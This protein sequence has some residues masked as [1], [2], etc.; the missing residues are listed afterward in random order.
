MS[1][2]SRPYPV[3]S[4]VDFHHARGPEVEHW[5]GVEN[6]GDISEWPL[7]PF[8]ALADGAHSSEEDFSYFTLR[9]NGGNGTPST[10]FGIACTRQLD[11]RQLIDRPVDVTRSTVQKAVVVIADSPTYFFGHLKE[12][13]SAVTQAWFAQRDFEDLDIIKRFRESLQTSLDTTNEQ[14]QYVG[15][16][17][18]EIVYDFKYQAL[19][20]F[21]CML[22]QP[23][24]LFFSTRCER[25]C[26]IQFSLISLVPGLLRC[27]QDSS[28]PDLSSYEASLSK[29]TSVRTSD[30]KSL[31]TFMGLPLQI[32]GKGSLFGPYTPLQQLDVLADVGTKSYMVGSTNSLLLQ[33]KDRYSD[34]LINLDEKT[35]NVTSSSLRTALNLSAADRRWIDYLVQTVAESWDEADPSRPKTMGFMGSEEYI[36]LQFEEYILSMVSSVKYHLFLEKHSGSDQ[37]VFLSDIEG[38]PSQ[39]FNTEFV[40]YWKKTENFRIFQKFTDSEIFDLVTPRHVM[41]GGL[42]MEDVQRRIALQVQELHLD[43]K[44][45]A[46]KEA[47]AKALATGRNNLSLAFMNISKNVEKFREQRRLQEPTPSTTTAENT[48]SENTAP[49]KSPVIES[50]PASPTVSG[51]SAYLSS[52]ATWA[53]EKRKKFSQPT[54][55]PASPPPEISTEPKNDQPKPPS[56]FSRWSKSSVDLPRSEEKPRSTESTEIVR[57]TVWE[58]APRSLDDKRL[59]PSPIDKQLPGLPASEISAPENL[60]VPSQPKE[61]KTSPAEIIVPV[62]DLPVERPLSEDRSLKSEK[63]QDQPTQP[64]QSIQPV[65]AVV[66]PP[67]VLVES[68][69]ITKESVTSNLPPLEPEP[70]AIAPE[71]ITIAPEP[72]TIAPEPIAIAPEPIAIAPDQSPFLLSQLLLLLPS[73]SNQLLRLSRLSL[74]SHQNEP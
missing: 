61:L 42:S 53:G 22:L 12:Q 57:E 39:D 4:I 18:R 20:L 23:K 40:D 58:E 16:S 15:L 26:M 36:R 74:K 64:E 37:N 31:L 51:A 55:Q 44:V 62:E 38:D 32:F 33:Q 7:L 28:D 6:E 25:L 50:T 73:L 41:A 70:I 49:E 8:L 9:H 71:P 1:R 35:V 24:M 63:I 69:P 21:K 17:L 60:H 59:P 47:A 11:S 14:E 34:I 46:G 30:R 29:P 19:V 2:K 72:I 10:L 66:N 54:S 5:I 27:L 56:L 45:N 52:W 67:T 13:L 65:E 48:A 43:E 68:E 3:V